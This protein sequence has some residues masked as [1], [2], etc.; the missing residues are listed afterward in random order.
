MNAEVRDENPARKQNS[1]IQRTPL[2][3][4]MFRDRRPVVC[5]MR[6]IKIG[7]E[8]DHPSRVMR[9]GRQERVEGLSREVDVVEQVPE[10]VQGPVRFL[11]PENPTF[12]QKFL[13]VVDLPGPNP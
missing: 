10:L 13:H 3:Q 8:G 5:S 11:D 7:D 6:D 12:A 2:G 9:R 1:N 4:N